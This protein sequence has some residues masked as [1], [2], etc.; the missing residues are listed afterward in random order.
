MAHGA[1]DRTSIACDL[2]ERPFDSRRP[3]HRTP[4]LGSARAVS[5]GRPARYAIKVRLGWK[6]SLS[7]GERSDHSPRR[8]FQHAAPYLRL[9]GVLRAVVSHL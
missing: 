2:F 5:I 9:I 4:P 8:G 1:Q 7:T 3:T 6:W